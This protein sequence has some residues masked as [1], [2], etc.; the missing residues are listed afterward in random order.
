MQ[1]VV[2]RDGLKQKILFVF[3][4][5]Y[6]DGTRGSSTNKIRPRLRLSILRMLPC[7]IQQKNEPTRVIQQFY[8]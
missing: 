1:Y 7:N 5:G 3:A 6:M 4:G 8:G 2:K